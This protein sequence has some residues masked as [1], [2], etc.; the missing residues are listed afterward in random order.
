MINSY[1]GKFGSIHSTLFDP[2]ALLTVT[3]SGQLMLVDLIERLTAAGVVVLSANTDGLFV[4]VPRD[5]VRWGD[6]VREWQDATGMPLE[7]EELS[8]LLLLATN[9]YATLSMSGEVKRKGAK[10]KGKVDPASAPNN[11]VIGDAIIEALFR[12]VPPERT[13]GQCQDLARFCSITRRSSKVVGLALVSADEKAVDIPEKIVRWYKAKATDHR[14]VQRRQQGNCTAANAQGIKL[15]MDLGDGGVPDDLDRS[16][17][18]REARKA[19][20]SVPGYRPLVEDL[21]NH[22]LAHAVHE[23][24]LLPVPKW[25]GK[26]QLPGSD[27]AAPSLL[28]DWD[29]YRTVGCYT[30]PA[31]GG[32][33]VVDVDDPQLFRKWV[34]HGQDPQLI[35]RWGDLAGARVVVRGEHTAEQVRSGLAPGKLIFRFESDAEHPLV[36]TPVGRWRQDRGIDVFFGQGLPSILGEHPDGSSYRLEGDLGAAPEWLT[37]GLSPPRRPGSS[38]TRTRTRAAVAPVEL[39]GL[40]SE[41]AYLEPRLGGKRIGW[42]EK[43][44]A[45]GRSIWVGRCPFPHESGTSSPDDLS[46]GFDPNGRPYVHCQHG[47]C[48]QIPIINR[49]LRET[50]IPPLD[51]VIKDLPELTEIA[52]AMIDDLAAGRV[53][54]HVAPT[55]AEKS[56]AT[57]QAVAA[58][59]RQGL[60][61]VVA[62]P[63]IR[64]AGEMK[65]KLK[66]LVPEA[67]RGCVAQIYGL[68]PMPAGGEDNEDDDAGRSDSGHYPIDSRTMIVIATRAQLGRRGFSTFIRALWTKLELAEDAR[69]K[70][71]PFSLIIDEAA[72]FLR[73]SRVEIPLKARARHQTEPDHNGSRHTF[74]RDCPKRNQSG[75]CAGCTLM[76]TGM[77]AA[78]NR[79]RIREL[80]PPRTIEY[81]AIN[82]PLTR[83]RDPLDVSVD[84][85]ELTPK[86]RVG[87]TTFAAKVLG[88]RGERIEA[89]ARRTAAIN[90]FQHDPS[91]GQ[92]HEAPDP[93][94]ANMLEFAWRPVITWEHPLDTEGNIVDTGEL[95]GRI[96]RREQGWDASVIFP[97][98]TCDVPRLQFADLAGVEK[99]RRFAD[100]QQ[101]GV[102]F[103]GVTL[104]RDD[105]DLLSEIWPE[106]LE[107]SHPYPQRKIRQLAIVAPDGNHGAGGLVGEAGRLVTAPLEEVGRGLVFLST[108]RIAN[109]LYEKV[110]Q[111]QPS[112]SFV[113]GGQ[114]EWRNRHGVYNETETR[115]LLTYSRG[116]LGLGANLLDT[117]FLLVDSLAYRSIASFTPGELT[118]EEFA[119]ARADERSSILAQNLGRLLRGEQ[120]KTAVL[121][122]LN[123]EP[124]LVQAVATAPAVVEG[125]ELPP[126]VTRGSD[127]VGSWPLAEGLRRGMAMLGFAEEVAQ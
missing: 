116:V 63:T 124:D 114:V 64:L 11:L 72:E 61:T 86:V 58:R 49:R 27:P 103:V 2:R 15:A 14:L 121:I 9:N 85:F 21:R 4:R 101:V 3:L 74:L 75:N 28:W 78:F 45:D 17:Y 23:K 33:L 84:D 125:S 24:G 6:V 102:L 39:R 118:P 77:Y 54:V 43:V 94:L 34:S 19:I 68:S 7:L 120:G 126:V 79:F 119:A 71:R 82:N 38:R 105:R 80:R 40:P 104:G 46:A 8:R 92:L 55:G 69:G 29:R 95:V 13:V 112:V 122:L 81:D 18:V 32:V 99:L 59:F 90:L 26:K 93:V 106:I 42:R 20:Q 109:E 25:G 97:R 31:G 62:C 91:G 115:T 16:W 50:Y 66:E 111:E 98:E 117:R 53:A 65:E 52:R 47:T 73:M 83:F 5:D 30:G 108:R 41:L 67:F 89:M 113:D 96:V 44:L 107:R 56:Y 1:L 76:A 48:T 87:G 100:D 57:A 36:G 35:S 123:A 22:P 10:L 127:L 37:G 51:Q 70:R 88:F 110:Y 12:D 60:P